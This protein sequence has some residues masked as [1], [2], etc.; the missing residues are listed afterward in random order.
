MELLAKQRDQRPDGAAAARERLEAA[1]GRGA[2]GRA[3]TAPG[4]NPL[5]RLAGGVF[6]GRERR[7]RAACARALDAALSGAG[8]LHAAG[9]RAGHRQDPDRRGA[10]DLRAGQRRPGLL[11]PLPRG[12]G[13]ARLLALGAGDAGPTSATRTRSR[14]RGRWAPAR[15]RSPQ[16]VPEVAERLDIEPAG[17]ADTEEARFRLF[18]SV[19]SFL[20][21]AA[22][23][24]P[25]G[26]LPRRPPLGRRALAAA[27]QAR[28]RARSASSGLL[29]VGTYRD[30]ELGR[31]HPLARVL[32]ELRR[33]RGS[34][35]A[36]FS[37]ADSSATWR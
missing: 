36:G 4:R 9:R 21:A 16:L 35:C 24:P 19:A 32:G 33:D 18:D 23:R 31:H 12:R 10:R 17:S 3:G 28:G 1:P 14:W 11:G 20:V 13:R 37:V 25:D 7:D 30:V 26:D 2:G 5:D 29:I 34:R 8:G 27:A 22:R 6:V 15:P